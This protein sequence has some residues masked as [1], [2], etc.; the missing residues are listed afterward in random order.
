MTEKRAVKYRYVKEKV[1][2]SFYYV[3]FLIVCPLIFLYFHLQDRD[4]I[5]ISFNANKELIC[6]VQSTKIN[7][8][9]KDNWIYENY[10]FIKGDS[11][12]ITTKCEEK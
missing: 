9:K 4:N 11:K 7:V 12:I 3:L 2:S 10:Y 8:S 5:L 1:E 6:K